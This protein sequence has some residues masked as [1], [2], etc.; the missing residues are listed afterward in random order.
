MTRCVPAA[1]ALL[2]LSACAAPASRPFGVPIRDATAEEARL[3]S[4]AVTPLLQ[5]LNDPTLH[6]PGCR[7]ALGVARSPRINASVGRAANDRCPRVAL[8]L[9]EGALQRLPVGMLRAVLAH[10]LGHV[11]LGHTGRHT[12]ASESAADEFAAALLKRL[13]PRHADACVQLV[14]VF[15]VLAE[16]GPAGWLA[17]HPSPDRRAE[18]ALASCNR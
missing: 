5:T 3:V 18:A 11:V 7:I 17:A 9:T 2:A 15:S 4:T 1:L 16:P 10:E 13:E 6:S 8:V 12:T 14:Y